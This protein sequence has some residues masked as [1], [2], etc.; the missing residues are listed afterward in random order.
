MHTPKMQL[1]SSSHT[2]Y[3]LFLRIK[4]KIRFFI[5][6]HELVPS[7]AYKFNIRP[8]QTKTQSSSD[9]HKF[10]VL[11][12]SCDSLTWFPGS[13]MRSKKSQNINNS[14]HTSDLIL[15]LQASWH[16]HEVKIGQPLTHNKFNKNARFKKYRLFSKN[17]RFWF[18]N[19]NQ[20]ECRNFLFTHYT[21]AQLC[22]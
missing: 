5:A 15:Y 20:H 2:S 19:T 17:N 3:C 4:A 1:Y 18:E 10:Q 11:T 21:T 12:N 7:Y 8:N 13:V 22:M 9:C 14:D 16:G 6:Q